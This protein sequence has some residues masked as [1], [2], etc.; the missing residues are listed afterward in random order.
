MIAARDLIERYSGGITGTIGIPTDY[1]N[2]FMLTANAFNLD[3]GAA[4]DAYQV[5]FLD[6]PRIGNQGYHLPDRVQFEIK[7]P[8]IFEIE[9]V[10][11]TYV[12]QGLGG[13]GAEYPS[14]K[15]YLI[16][17]KAGTTT[18]TC[19][20]DGFVGQTPEMVVHVNSPAESSVEDLAGKLTDIRGRERTSKYDTWHYFAGQRGAP[21][22]FKVN[23]ADPQVS[24]YDYL[25][26]D[27]AGAATRTEYPVDADGT[28]TVLLKDG[29]NPIEVSATYDGQR[30][31]QVYGLKGKVI[32]Y[33]LA[34]VTDPEA[35]DSFKEGDTASLKI[36]GLATPVHKMLRIYNPSATQFWFDTNLPRYD[37]IKSGGGQY[38]AGEMQFVVTDAGK[39]VLRNGRIFQDWFGSPL[40]SETDAPGGGMAPQSQK[41]FSIIPDIRFSV[42]ENPAY[43][44]ELI[45]PQIEGGAT[46]KA[47]VKATILLPTLNT[48]LLAERYQGQDALQKAFTVFR[49][50]IP[51]CDPVSSKEV[52]QTADLDDLKTVDLT[53]PAGTAPGQYRIYGGRVD[54]TYGDP[55]WLKYADHF[56]T[57]IDDLTVEVTPS[58]AYVGLRM[59]KADAVAALEAYADPD[60]YRQAQ[61][62]ELAAAV[63]AGKQAIDVADDEEAVAAALAEAQQA[64]DAIATADELSAAEDAEAIAAAK[65]MLEGAA[66]RATQAQAPDEAAALAAVEAILGGLDLGGVEA[67]V[68]PV[69]YQAPQAGTAENPAGADGAYVFTVRLSKGSAAEQV[70]GELTLVIT[71]T[72]KAPLA[73]ATVTLAVRADGSLTWTGRKLRPAVRAVTIGGEAFQQG[74][75]FEVAYGRNT[76]VGQGT[77]TLTATA[78]GRLSGE[79]ALAFKIIPRSTAVRSLKAGA[80]RLT[81]SFR[82]VTRKL[83]LRHYRIR[84]RVAGARAWQQRTITRSYTD[85]KTLA[86][87]TLRG[88]QRGKRYQVTVLAGK[89]VGGSWY[90]SQP[91][92]VKTSPR[93]K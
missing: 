15:Y 41:M 32:S 25:G 65:A 47:G 54:V 93:I 50:D 72:A 1:P 40:Y 2:D 78:D 90:W 86:T 11:Y 37:V 20:Y 57:E 3:L 84:Y 8:S 87:Q 17:K 82:E 70:T 91:A 39:A 30:V 63:A 36:K 33:E 68:V 46:V 92:K 49:T 42:A 10:P 23:G 7:D 89:R 59:A 4:D 71:A 13:G 67:T 66:W 19:S 24:V 77:V 31:T 62:A 81:V 16:P 18:F 76:A 12:D 6:T 27:E 61:R 64:I 80:R 60:D 26:Y 88:L 83:Q 29:Y 34:N 35:G 52:L 74:A 28:V 43:T 48:G 14:V 38:D 5:V 45:V 53:V 44:P 58:D 55:T 56:V 85:N 22:T 79:L 73:E 21:F 69:S 51:N 9:A 75:D